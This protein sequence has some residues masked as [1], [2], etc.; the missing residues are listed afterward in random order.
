[1]TDL[2]DALSR[3]HRDVERLFAVPRRDRRRRLV[4]Q[5]RGRR[6]RFTPKLDRRPCSIRSWSHVDD[7]DDMATTRKPSTRRSNCRSPAS[8]ESP[9]IDLRPVIDEIRKGVE[10][11]VMIE[12]SEL[13]PQLRE[14]GTDAEALGQKLAD[15]KRSTADRR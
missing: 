3:D 10:H 4:A 5:D 1:M 11:H 9:P 15:F 7:G 12:E 8:T 14:A 6:R 13:F 2:F